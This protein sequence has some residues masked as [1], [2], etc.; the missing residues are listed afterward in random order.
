MNLVNEINS[1]K[2]L[3]KINK[4]KYIT[5]RERK[6]YR[7]CLN[8]YETFEDL[9]LNLTRLYRLNYNAIPDHLK[10]N[11]KFLKK[12]CFANPKILRDIFVI[13]FHDLANVVDL[14]TDEELIKI[15][16]KKSAR[17]TPNIKKTVLAIKGIKLE[18][19]EAKKT[20]AL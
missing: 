14:F 4:L 8:N 13:S 10:K 20:I 15:T 5:L 11:Y 2:F 3:V 19:A 6:Y 18:D 1:I 16:N 9:F 12:A 17:L 7:S